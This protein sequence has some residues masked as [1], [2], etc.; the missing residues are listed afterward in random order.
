MGKSNM[1]YFVARDRVTNDLNIINIGNTLEEIDLYTIQYDNKDELIKHLNEKGIITGT[2]L[3]LYI[4]IPKNSSKGKY[5][6]YM[7]VLY[8]DS[9]GVEDIARG[10]L[11]K[12][13]PTHLVDAVLNKFCTNIQHNS[14]FFDMVTL[15]KTNIY[16]KFT[17]YFIGR[18]Y[19][20]VYDVKYYDGAWVQRSYPVIRNIYDAFSKFSNIGDRKIEDNIYRK[21]LEDK[22]LFKTNNDVQNNQMN[23]FDYS[24]FSNENSDHEDKLLEI[25][26]TF[27]NLDKDIFNKDDGKIILSREKFSKIS[28]D[29]FN[30]F[31][32]LLDRRLRS[33]VLYYLEHK[34]LKDVYYDKNDANNMYD[35]LIEDD[36]KGIL[37]LLKNETIFNNAYSWITVYNKYMLGEEYGKQKRKGE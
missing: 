36:Q 5:V 35:R 4:A 2:D 7:D 16:S 8:S 18:R 12:N 9:R 13:I 24:E 19:D 22:F 29:E 1:Y 32:S 6:N 15:G 31:N 27:D 28:E 23:L 3:D 26:T 34:N 33:Y 21:I 14:R 20:K 25:I 17:D 37:E 11:N 30:S 10:F